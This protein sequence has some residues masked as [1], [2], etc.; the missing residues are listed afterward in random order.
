MMKHAVWFTLLLAA[1]VFVL[2]KLAGFPGGGEAAAAAPPLTLSP[3][4]LNEDL[5]ASE[6]KH[7]LD[8]DNSACYVCHGNYDG[9]ELVVEHGKEGTGCMDCHGQSIDHRND[10]DN[11]TPPDKMYASGDVDKMCGRC[12]KEHNVPAADV[13]AKWQRRCPTKTDPKTIVCTDCHGEHRLKSRSVRWDKKTGKLIIRKKGERI[14]MAP[15]PKKK[16]G[17][18]PDEPPAPETKTR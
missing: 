6:E 18:P 12:H 4:L 14:K 1:V 17:Q 15:D 9:E 2:G 10:E 8:V 11:I 3:E 13:I 5:P 7:V 16:T